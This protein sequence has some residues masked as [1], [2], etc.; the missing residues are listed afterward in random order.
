MTAILSGFWHRAGDFVRID[1]TVG[2][3]MSKIP[4][5]AI[6]MSRVRATF[7]TVRKALVDPVTIGLVHNDENATVCPCCRSSQ[8]G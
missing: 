3:G 1:A 6:G 5:L 2:G 8:K 7:F 4:L